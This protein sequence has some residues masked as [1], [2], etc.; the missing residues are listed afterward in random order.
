MTG[1]ASFGD[2][3]RRRRRQALWRLVRLIVAVAA[4]LGFGGYTYQIGASASQARTEKLEQD[5]VR[6]QEANLDLRDQLTLTRRRSSETEQALE[7]LRRR[8]ASEVPTGELAVLL[9]Q[10]EEQLADGVAPKRLA[11]LIDAAGLEESCRDAP[12]TKRFMPATAISSGPVSFVRFD[13]R[14]T[15]TGEGDPA[16]SADGLPEAWYDAA[17]PVRLDFQALDGAVVSVRGIVPLVHRMVFD[18]REYRFSAVA[19]DR[20]FVEI[21]A[22]VCALPGFGAEPVVQ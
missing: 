10:V 20:G 22:Q 2:T 5:L 11:F 12:E 21:T 16:R 18:G 6:F 8:Y 3:R 7:E 9:G 17:A 14:I 13:E 4:V 1:Y 19:G 15:I